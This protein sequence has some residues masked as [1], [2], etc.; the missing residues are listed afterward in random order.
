MEM[1]QSFLLKQVREQ[2]GYIWHDRVGGVILKW[3]VVL[4]VVAVGV[5]GW[6]YGRLPPEIPLWL[7]RPWGQAQLAGKE[8]VWVIPGSL[9]GLTL[10]TLAIAGMA[11][12][13]E[14]LLARMVVGGMGLTGLML[15]YALI[16]IINLAL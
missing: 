6:S 11:Y 4:I 8:W 12:R 7:S 13:E 9:M 15:V 5:T 3:L 1:G 2:S 10:I 14:K 16:R